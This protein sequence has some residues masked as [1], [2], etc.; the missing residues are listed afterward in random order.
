VFSLRNVGTGRVADP[1][2]EVSEA[3]NGNLIHVRVN[4]EKEES[5]VDPKKVT[6]WI[7]RLDHF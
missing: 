3:R 7:S 2:S 4:G 6:A 1:L 5:K